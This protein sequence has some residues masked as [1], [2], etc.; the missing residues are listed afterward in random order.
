[1]PKGRR[2][3]SIRDG[4]E[5]VSRLIHHPPDEIA[6]A[7]ALYNEETDPKKKLTTF[8]EALNLDQGPARKVI[9]MLRSDVARF[10]NGNGEDDEDKLPPIPAE[11]REVLSVMTSMDRLK[12]RRLA[13]EHQIDDLKREQVKIDEEMRQYQPVLEKAAALQKAIH[14][15]RQD[16][17]KNV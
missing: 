12:A 7:F 16:V 14:Q 10:S 4:L 9:G 5:R 17:R 15:M 6:A 2:I 1:M 13:L 3:T 8:T 11:F